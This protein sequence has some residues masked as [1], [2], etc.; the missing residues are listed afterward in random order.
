[1]DAAWAAIIA[2]NHRPATNDYS[3]YRR[4]RHLITTEPDDEGRLTIYRIGEAQMRD[5]LGRH[6]FWYTY[7]RDSGYRARQPNF[8]VVRD[9]PKVP[10]Q[11]IPRLRRISVTPFIAETA[12]ELN[13]AN[14]YYP[15]ER[16]L[17]DCPVAI[18]MMDVPKAVAGLRRPHRGLPI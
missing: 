10:H 12:D 14:G 13:I 3:L 9:L 15:N 11:D 16:I 2:A 7:A 17:M 4:D 8:N 5:I 6:I 1:M 18:E